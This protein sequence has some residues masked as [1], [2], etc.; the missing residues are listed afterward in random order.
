MHLFDHSCKILVRMKWFD[1][2]KH[3]ITHEEKCVTITYKTER[4]V[5]VANALKSQYNS[6]RTLFLTYILSCCLHHLHVLV[7]RVLLHSNLSCNSD[8]NSMHILISKHF[9]HNDNIISEYI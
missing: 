9:S 8:S 2:Y 1:M 5:H 6:D 7:S 3:L 4:P